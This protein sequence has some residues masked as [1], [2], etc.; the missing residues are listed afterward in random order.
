MNNSSDFVID[1]SVL[2][3]YTGPGGDVVIPEGVTAISMFFSG[4]RTLQSIS[5]PEGIAYI[6]DFMFHHCTSLRHISI[7]N[8]VTRIGQYAFAGCTA[9]QSI[10]IPS[11]VTCIERN[12]FE[13]CPHLQTVVISE[14][15]QEIGDGAFQRCWNLESISIPASVTGIADYAFE[16]YALLKISAPEGSYAERFVRET[17]SPSLTRNSQNFICEQYTLTRYTGPGGHVIIP[18]GV[19]HISEDAFASTPAPI[20]SVAFHDTMN[21]IDMTPLLP[22][23]HC[24][25]QIY[26]GHPEAKVSLQQD[27]WP[28]H[29]NI[30]LPENG[31]T[32]KISVGSGTITVSS[33]EP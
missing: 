5:L 27:S 24:L 19:A 16:S 9:L 33:S 32:V 2:I 20:T 15:V 14:G 26:I 23:A 11:G 13:G 25:D 6:D 3:N 12:T 29:A 8:S 10:T 31:G 7:P 21:H 4:N 30:C 18:W 17:F 28:F 1:D 22:H